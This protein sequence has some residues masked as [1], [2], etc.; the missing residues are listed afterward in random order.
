MTTYD[1]LMNS[2]AWACDLFAAWAEHGPEQQDQAEW[3][4]R[5]VMVVIGV[6]DARS[7]MAPGD[8]RTVGMDEMLA[9]GLRLAE[10]W[11]NE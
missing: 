1:D 8:R 4:A 10:E 3:M 6:Y 7:R 9:A 5:G 2:A 11:G